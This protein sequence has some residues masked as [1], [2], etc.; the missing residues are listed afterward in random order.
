MKKVLLSGSGYV[1]SRCRV[2][3]VLVWKVIIPL[4]S[5]VCRERIIGAL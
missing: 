1:A 5:V 3:S 4:V 2:V